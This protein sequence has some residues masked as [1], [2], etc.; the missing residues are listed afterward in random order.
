MI[1]ENLKKLMLRNAAEINRMHAR[2]HET[3]KVRDQSPE[4]WQEWM[5]ACEDGC[6]AGS[7]DDYRSYDERGLRGPV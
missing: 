3:P 2:I 6:G 7:S 1:P 4:K 5:Q